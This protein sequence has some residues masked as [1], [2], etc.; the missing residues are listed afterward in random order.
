LYY[1]YSLT[2]PK[3][4][5]KTNPISLP[6]KLREGILT[7][8]VVHVPLGVASTTYVQL[9]DGDN[10]IAPWLPDEAI[11]GDGAEIALHPYYKIPHDDYVLTIKAW[12][13][14]TQYD[15]TLRFR[16]EILPEDIVFPGKRVVQTLT[17]L[18][19]FWW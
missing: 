12:N 14:S 6:I 5:P 19:K 9:Y 2:V 10:I 8:F 15:H 11:T 18:L 3:N 17:N 1:E 16:L 13:I 7:T 4:T